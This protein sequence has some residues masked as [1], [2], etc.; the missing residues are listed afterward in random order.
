[1]GSILEHVAAGR[2]GAVE[3]CVDAYGDFVFRLARRYLNRADA[4]VD[5]AVQEVFVELW[6]SAKRFDPARG[7]ERAFV[8]TIAHRRL[9]DMQRH[10]SSRRA[11]DRARAHA[12]AP[13][14]MTANVSDDDHCAVARA[15]DALPADERHALWLAVHGGLTH[16]Q[17][18]RVTEVPVGTVKTRLR[19][20][21]LHLRET[22]SRVM[23]LG[24]AES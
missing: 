1:M 18:S 9:I 15:F 7:S 16:Q 22:L 12:D 5:D 2:S 10:V 11:T 4:F 14:S 19:R 8:A 23:T 20:G 6:T 21:I 17:I 13:A 3:A 24:G